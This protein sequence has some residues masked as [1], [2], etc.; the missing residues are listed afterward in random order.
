MFDKYEINKMPGHWLLARM[1]K[2]VLRPGGVELTDLMLKE[3][4]IGQE[5]VVIE[6][7]PGIGATANKILSKNPKAY[8]GID[9]SKEAITALSK[10]YT[11]YAVHFLH[12]YASDTGLQ[13]GC[14]SKVIGEA[15]LTMQTD[16]NKQKIID[17]A[18]RLL[19]PDG[20]YA[21]HEIC[22]V[23]DTI[24]EQEKVELSE[25]LSSGIHVN[26]RPLTVNE[27]RIL[28]EQAGFK[29]EKI[30]FT[31]MHLLEV[32]RLLKDEGFYGLLKIGFNAVKTSGA[33]KRILEMRRM[34]NRFE[35][36]MKAIS[37]IAVKNK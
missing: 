32:G 5:D 34:F 15:M 14:A 1:G 7:A 36:N 24:S 22:L 35:P 3:L 10:T 16:R 4:E 12:S 33:L 37:I 29:I 23:P 9:Q 25:G 27:W 26:A 19:K 20:K 31:P 18:F 6:F 17:E 2:K 28:F 21:V 8:Y 11:D 13:E 30:M